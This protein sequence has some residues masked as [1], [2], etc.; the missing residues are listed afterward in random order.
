MLIDKTIRLFLD[1][2]GKR[3]EYEFYLQKFQAGDRPAFAIVAPDIDSLRQGA[4]V[5]VFDLQFLLQV[6]LLPV[7][8][9]SGPDAEEMSSLI[10]P[11]DDVCVVLGSF[12]LEDHEADRNCTRTATVNTNYLKRSRHY[13]YQR[14]P[15]TV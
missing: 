14:R 9:L 6:D 13:A 7:V 8:V 2:I 11:F 12:G 1:G 3:E 10:R 5:L 15:K 4:D